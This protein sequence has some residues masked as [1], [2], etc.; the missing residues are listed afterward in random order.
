[1]TERTTGS[2]FGRNFFIFCCVLALLVVVVPI[3]LYV[4][5]DRSS[6]AAYEQALLDQEAAA[7]EQFTPMMAA[8]EEAAKP[9]KAYDIDKTVRVI[10]EI[11]RAMQREGSLEEYVRW[12]ARQDYSDVAPE[13]LQARK[14]MLEPILKL[15]AKQVELDDQAEM[16]EMTSEFLLATLSVVSVDGEASLINPTANLSV[17]REQAKKLF[18]DLKQDRED[19]KQLVKDVANIETELFGKMMDYSE[20]YYRYIEEWD[21]LSILRDRAYLAA[22]N[23]EWE[24]AAASA[25]LA[26]QKSPKEREAHLLKAMALIELDNR[27][28]A[29]EI[30]GL[31]E[32]YVQEHADSTAPALL[33]MGVHQARLGQ[34]AQAQLSFQQAAAYFPKQAAQLTDMLNPYEMRGF[35]RQSREGQFIVEMYKSTMLGAGYFSPD[36]Q[37][38]KALFDKGDDEA[39]RAKVLDHFARR[40]TQQQWD[41]IISDVAFCQ[42]LLGPDFWKILPERTYLDLEVS[43]TMMGGSLNLGVKNRSEK[44]LHNATLVLA[45]QFTD[46]YAGDY[47]AIAAPD[48]VPAVTAHD[49]TSFGT[50]PIAFEIFGKQKSVSEIVKTRAILIADEAVTWVDTDAYRIAEDKEF[51]DQ[52]RIDSKLDTKKQ[53]EHPLAK[54]HPEFK[55]TMD[56]LLSGASQIAQ[57]KLE[58][59]YGA[60]NLVVQLPRE[61]AIL[62]P[63][64]RLKYGDTLYEA[65]D[66]V[67]DGDKIELRFAGVQNFDAEGAPPPD[68]MELL[69]GSPFGDVVFSWKNNG[70]LSWRFGGAKRE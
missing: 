6:R 14:D 46:M 49:S 42:D 69:M 47:E 1:M 21:Q 12:S 19:H 55:S 27:E 44:V 25:D 52:K 61:L 17:D 65:Q 40:R 39:G 5:W 9:E 38:A 18:E 13:V 20:V 51:R 2:S 34:E 48:T 26:I 54:R 62:R 43:K 57:V 68:D 23:G 30:E 66:N 15:Y 32:E 64:F 24:A 35:L 7:E 67:I 37:L 22:Y 70:D 8:L 29:A 53:V 11:D 16:W 4:W 41:F 60:D 33:L 36:L 45:V 63:M 3:G 58:E 59:K 28:N 31:L 50:V 10:H 56:T